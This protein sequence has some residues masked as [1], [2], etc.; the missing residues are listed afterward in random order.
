MLLYSVYIAVSLL[1]GAIAW[2]SLAWMLHAWRNPDSLMDTRL[3]EDVLEP[4]N[5]F[6]LIVPARHEEAVLEATLSRLVTSDH[7]AFEVLV[8][9]GHDDPTTRAV[10]ERVASRHPDLV[11][12]IVD[13]NAPKNKPR[14]L[15]TALPHCAGSITGVFDA[16]DEVHP[17]LLRRID[18]RFQ[19]TDAE[20]VQAGVQLMNFRSSWI[21][22]RNVLEY[23]FWFRSRLHFHAE[24]RFIPLGG[25]TVFVRTD[26]LRSVGGWDPDCLAEDCE[27]GVRLSSLGVRTVVVYQPEL[28]TREECPPSLRAFARQRTRWNQGF[29]QTLSRG[30]WRRLPRRQRALGVYTLAMPYVLALAWLLIPVAIGTAVAVKAPVQITLISFLPAIPTL[31]ILAVELAG[32]GDFCRA[33]GERPSLRDYARLVLGLLPYQAVLAFAAARAVAREV[34][35]ARGWE[36]T[37]HLG[38]HLTPGDGEG[39]LDGHLRVLT[40]GLS[41]RPPL[42]PA[43][44]EPVRVL[45]R[46]ISSIHAASLSHPQIRSVPRPGT[47]DAA[48]HEMLSGL[49]G[50]LVGLERNLPGEQSHNGHARS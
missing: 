50:A 22:V 11:R 41:S 16:E 45:L 24:H 25:N 12:V 10:A 28:A 48:L 49:D 23:Y 1:L 31:S 42:E 20:V 18:Q 38:L 29:L 46:A 30:Y 5:S 21:A 36:K 15:N 26:L 35:G 34:R 37:Q 47:D 33:Y 4:R 44:D 7:P 14:A 32:L 13:T 17:A 43:E 9:V 3:D 40:G 19:R 39:R 2:T 27:L 8:V 6:S